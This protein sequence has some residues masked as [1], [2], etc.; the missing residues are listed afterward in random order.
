MF[1]LNKPALYGIIIFPIVTWVTAFLYVATNDWFGSSDL[2]PFAFWAF[3]F[4]IPAFPILLFLSNQIKEN[5]KLKV[6][7]WGIFA[8]LTI[9]IVSI[10]ILLLIL[11]PWVGAF[12]FPFAFCILFGASLGTAITILLK[13]KGAWLIAGSQAF[14]LPLLF[15]T[16]SYT[17]YAKPDNLIVHISEQASIEDINNVWGTLLNQE[18]AEPVDPIMKNNI[19]GIARVDKDGEIRLMVSFHNGVRNKTIDTI[20]ERIEAIDFVTRT[21]IT[22]EVAV[23]VH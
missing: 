10:L 3:I 20:I 8:T 13:L 7:F 17:L 18:G 23:K 1:K 21:S 19:Q 5:A 4:T 16:M 9:F 15:L 14:T 12:S 11:G 22:E 6:F 2:Q